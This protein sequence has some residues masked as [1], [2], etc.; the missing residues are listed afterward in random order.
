[1]KWED[2]TQS[3]QSITQKL[4]WRSKAIKLIWYG[5]SLLMYSQGF[6]CNRWENLQSW[7]N[8]YWISPI[9]EVQS[10]GTLLEVELEPKRMKNLN[11]DRPNRHH[12]LHLIIFSWPKKSHKPL[13]K[14]FE[15]R[16]KAPMHLKVRLQWRWRM[17]HS[18]NHAPSWIWSTQPAQ[19]GQEQLLKGGVQDAL[20]VGGHWDPRGHGVR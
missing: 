15:R 14:K 13:R 17:P 1:M 18:I 5:K 16:L 10:K 11:I 6:C 20:W 9:I 2:G 8:W 12:L 7:W 4:G 19:V 3:L